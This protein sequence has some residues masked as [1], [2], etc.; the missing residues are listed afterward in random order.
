MA[1]SVYIS[2]LNANEEVFT[3]P[4][5]FHKW[6]PNLFWVVTLWQ[7]TCMA[8]LNFRCIWDLPYSKQKNFK[9]LVFSDRSIIYSQGWV[10]VVCFKNGFKVLRQSVGNR[11]RS[12]LPEGGHFFKFY[13]VRNVGPKH[14]IR[15]RPNTIFLQLFT[16]R[17]TNFVNILHHYVKIPGGGGVLNI[18]CLR[19]CAVSRGII[20]MSWISSV[21][22]FTGA[23]HSNRKGNVWKRKIVLFTLCII[24]CI[25]QNENYCLILWRNKKLDTLFQQYSRAGYGFWGKKFL[26]GTTPGWKCYALIYQDRENQYCSGRH[27]SNTQII[28]SDSARPP[29]ISNQ[30]DSFRD[31]ILVTKTAIFC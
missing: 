11:A 15:T 23:G 10:S 2:A 29:G 31:K 24:V 3:L 18:F 27:V 1:A 5:R 26:V 9:C 20:L 8:V 4:W 28:H 19:G 16:L 7:D 22:F 6:Q 13:D 25:L 21:N 30:S 12:F 14:Q 17:Y